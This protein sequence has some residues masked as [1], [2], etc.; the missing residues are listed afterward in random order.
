MCIIDSQLIENLCHTRSACAVSI[1]V[2]CVLLTS[3][4]VYT[5]LTV[6]SPYYEMDIDKQQQL[7]HRR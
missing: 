4:W 5:R 7:K 6:Y 3:M 2:E 1:R